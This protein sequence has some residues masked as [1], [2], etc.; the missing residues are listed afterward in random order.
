MILSPHTV[1][2][3]KE[4]EVTSDSSVH[5]EAWSYAGLLQVQLSGSISQ[6]AANGNVDI[7]NRAST[8]EPRVQGHRRR[9]LEP[10]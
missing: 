7:M 1:G 9:K 4:E 10:T 5:T 6:Q 8:A 2:R 3:E